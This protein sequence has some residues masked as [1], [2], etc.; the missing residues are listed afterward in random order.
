MLL[1]QLNNYR[2]ILGSGS[3]RRRQLLRELGLQFE[4]RPIGVEESYP[5]NLKGA[6]IA[7]YLAELKSKAY[8][9]PLKTNDLLL[10]SDTIVWSKNTMLAKPEDRQDAIRMISQLSGNWHEVITSI[11]LRTNTHTITEHCSTEVLFREL[12]RDEI[13]YYID[14]YKPYDKAGAYGIQEWIGMVGITEIRG[15]YS[16]VVGLPTA[17]LWDMLNKLNQ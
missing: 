3:P 14:T 1:N 10:T 2:I 16:N 9:E 11:C 4:V 7:D 8:P 15:S 6:A 12:K 17:L 5:Q 13:E